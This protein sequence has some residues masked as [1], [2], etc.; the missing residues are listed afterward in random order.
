MTYL[1]Q[2]LVIVTTTPWLSEAEREAEELS[3]E[4]AAIQQQMEA[5]DES[6]IEIVE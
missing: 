4:R 5:E 2:V 1:E 3:A 6:E